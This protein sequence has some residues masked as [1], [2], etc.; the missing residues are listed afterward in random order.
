MNEIF[1]ILIFNGRPAA[2]KSEV[3]DYIKHCPLERGSPAST[4]ERSRR[5]MTSISFGSASRTMT[6]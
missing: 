6:S 5:S 3:I 2:G 4:S 1:P